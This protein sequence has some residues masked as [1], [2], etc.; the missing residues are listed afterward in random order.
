MGLEDEW[1][2]SDVKEDPAPHTSSELAAELDVEPSP[3][4]QLRF[5]GVQILDAAGCHVERERSSGTDRDRQWRFGG[6]GG[7][8]PWTAPS[9]EE[10]SG[11][12]TGFPERDPGHSKSG[13]PELPGRVGLNDR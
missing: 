13:A 7:G 9:A 10:T 1:R 12:W 8:E 6:G 11:L 4:L 5:T 3:L 2:E